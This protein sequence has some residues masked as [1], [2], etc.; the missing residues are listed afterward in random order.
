LPAVIKEAVDTHR[1]VILRA[2]WREERARGLLLD[3]R[4]RARAVPRHRREPARPPRPPRPVGSNLATPRGAHRALS[5]APHR[6]RGLQPRRRHHHAGARRR[7]RA[8]AAVFAGDAEG[9][10]HAGCSW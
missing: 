5:L 1:L 4:E 2:P 10:L 8:T 6:P 7:A 3:R 9:L